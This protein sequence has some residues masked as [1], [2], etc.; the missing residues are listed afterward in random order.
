MILSHVSHSFF[1]AGFYCLAHSPSSPFKIFTP[2]IIASMAY[3][4]F[5]RTAFGLP[6]RSRG[7]VGVPGIR[8]QPATV[9]HWW[10]IYRQGKQL[11][12]LPEAHWP[13]LRQL[14]IAEC[15]R[16]SRG[17]WFF[18]QQHHRQH[19]FQRRSRS[20]YYIPQRIISYVH[21]QRKARGL[22]TPGFLHISI[23]CCIAIL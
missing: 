17:P 8:R 5:S 1:D 3:S 10:W 14:S 13:K 2:W 22:I 18:S 23:I 19:R 12:T 9:Y 4:R 15:Y 7:Q 16:F 11:H 20:L 21:L 6:G